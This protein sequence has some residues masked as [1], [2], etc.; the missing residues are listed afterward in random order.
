ME[1]LAAPI[2]ESVPLFD[3]SFCFLGN[4]PFGPPFG[5]L[6]QSASDTQEAEI[7]FA[8]VCRLPRPAEAIEKLEI[9]NT[10]LA[11]PQGKIKKSHPGSFL[12]GWWVVQDSNLWPH[13]RQA[14]ALP[15]ELTTPSPTLR[16]RADSNR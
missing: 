10:H 12:S 15:A 4:G 11:L 9:V 5:A 14:C 1:R 13:A 3:K 2:E 8:P 6:D 16:R 7:L